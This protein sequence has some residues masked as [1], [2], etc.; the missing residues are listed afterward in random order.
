[1]VGDLEAA[2]LKTK[3]PPKAQGRMV[4]LDLT[5][6]RMLADLLSAAE[7]ELAEGHCMPL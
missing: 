3:A 2:R 6:E 5:L 7:S 1:M 4:G